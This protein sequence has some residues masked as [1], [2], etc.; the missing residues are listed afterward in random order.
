MS[1]SVH[2]FRRDLRLGDNSALAEAQQR[3]DLVLPVFVFDPAL[4]RRSDIGAPRVAFLLDCLRKLSA[5][6]EDLGSQLIV[7]RGAPEQQIP[8]L[9]RRTGASWVTVHRDYSPYGRRRD[10]QVRRRIEE[11]GARWIEE[12]GV[13]L[14]EPENCVKDDGRPY[15]V[16]TPFARRWRLAEKKAPRR[17]AALRPLPAELLARAAGTPLPTL[18]ELGLSLSAE[19][20]SGG[21]RAARQRLDA[22]IACGLLGYADRRDLPGQPGTSRL[23]AHLKLGTI[24]PRTVYER[25]R[26]VAGDE[27]VRLDPARPPAALSAAQRETL[28]QTGVFLNEICWRD[29]YQSILFHFPHVATGPFQERYARLR[30]PESDPELIAAWRDGQTGFPIVDAAMRQLAAIGWMHNRLRMIVA[31]FLSKTLLVDWRVGERIFMQRLVDGDLAANNGGWQWCASTGTD[32]APYF[33]IFNPT[34]QAQK[35]DPDG[36]FLRRWVPEL[37]GAPGRLVFE[38]WRENWL[39]RGAYPERC[40]DFTE[41]RVR[42]L[43]LFELARRDRAL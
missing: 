8:S 26:T 28:R 34:L 39:G 16:F 5:D 42:A 37:R 22:F 17:R 6:L 31:T 11:M 21:E 24:S 23:S 3:G 41:R 38:P 40:V 7:L 25:V 36:T 20:E 33:R 18:E 13:L 19:I 43:D 29:F 12:T 14:V 10:R 35:F 30:W 9:L 4:L 2:W 15:T 32:S 27:L 1:I